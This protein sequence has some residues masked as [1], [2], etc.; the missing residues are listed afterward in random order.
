MEA[1]AA[2]QR[3][4]DFRAVP[5]TTLE[6]LAAAMELCRYAAG[7][8]IYEEGDAAEH[9]YLVES[10]HVSLTSI[11]TGGEVGFVAEVGPGS[12][13]GEMTAFT[14]RPRTV[15]AIARTDCV[16]WKIPVNALRKAVFAD[17]QLA[18]DMMRSAMDLVLEK[19]LN[20]IFTRQH[21]NEL[22]R[23]VDIERQTVSRLMAD[24]QRRDERIAIM[25][26][27]VRSPLAVIVGCTHILRDRWPTLDDDQRQ[28]L[29]ESISR[30]AGGLLGLVQDALEVASIET[31]DLSYDIRPLDMAELVRC[32]VTDLHAADDSLNVVTRVEREL[33]RA[34]GDEQR[35]REILFNLLTNAVKFS[36]RGEPI[37]VELDA[38]AERLTVSVTDHGIGIDPE[39]A[40]RIFAKFSRGKHP[41]GDGLPEGFGLGLYICKSLVEAQG[42]RIWVESTPG[43]GSSFKYTLP[44]AG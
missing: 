32:L 6:P 24:H 22:R 20:V 4:V 38:D 34:L 37:E 41:D 43:E 15:S 42:G 44:L 36:P 25:A 10:G 18:W 13:L 5:R 23:A 29:L 35:H 17:A 12:L 16:L 30:Q 11:R 21:A 33:P 7:T 19:D 28:Q 9:A 31:G 8:V 40:Q 26:H 2:L 27:D 39:D 14:E 1:L 3:A